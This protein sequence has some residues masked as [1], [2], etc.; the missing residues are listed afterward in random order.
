MKALHRNRPLELPDLDEKEVMALK[1]VYK[2]QGSAE[3]Q[4]F[5]L[6][7][8]IKK[9]CNIGGISFDIDPHVTS[10]NEGKRV[11]GTQMLFLINEPM[12]KLFKPKKEP[13]E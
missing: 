11:V 1:A 10:L 6:E 12:N 13:K 9:F 3:D 2:G 4:T 8:I 5:V 7:T